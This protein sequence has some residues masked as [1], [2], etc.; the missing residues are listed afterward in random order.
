MCFLVLLI[1]FV[2][3]EPCLSFVNFSSTP[4]LLQTTLALIVLN[5]FFIV[6]RGG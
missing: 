5:A 4:P 6:L 3:L 2:R 1:L